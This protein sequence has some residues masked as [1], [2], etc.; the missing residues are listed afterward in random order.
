MSEYIE[1]YFEQFSPNMVS[2]P[3]DSPKEYTNGPFIIKSYI[4]ESST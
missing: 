2:P 3:P 1:D 4:L